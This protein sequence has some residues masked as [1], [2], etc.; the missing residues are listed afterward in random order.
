MQTLV[1]RIPTS[2]QLAGLPY[3]LSDRIELRPGVRLE[4]KHGPAVGFV[5]SFL[6]LEREPEFEAIG[7]DSWSKLL[8]TVACAILFS[9]GHFF[10]ARIWRFAHSKPKRLGR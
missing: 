4:F 5:S 9:F 1:F 3:A 6:Y 10:T 8:R 2:I 7:P